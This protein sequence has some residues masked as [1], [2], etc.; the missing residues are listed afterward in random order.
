MTSE[1]N[2]SER[3]LVVDDSVAIVSLL[4][5]EI[6]P[7]G[8]YDV[9]AAYSGE[10]GLEAIDLVN[11]DLILC[12]LEMPGIS[13]LDMLRTLQEKRGDVPAI[14]M[15]AF[16]SEAVATQALR[17]GVKDYIVKPFTTD[18]ILA[19]IE[20]ALAERR[21]LVKLKELNRNLNEY[22]QALAVLQAISQATSQGLEPTTLLERII[23]AAVFAG[24]AQG[25]FVARLNRDANRLEVQA[26]ANLPNWEAKQI[27]L[28]LDPA[29]SAALG[30]TEATRTTSRAGYWY[31]IPLVRQGAS[32]GLMSIVSRFE[33]LPPSA[34][35]IF[36]T[37]AS[38]VAYTFENSQLRSELAV[39]LL[40][41]N[42]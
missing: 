2:R 21:L 38:C 22:H 19:S 18:E 9:T 20:R 35:P 25:G 24:K 42:S 16:G 7:L 4:A 5:N 14:M 39:A 10:E 17:M 31:H 32:I 13:G 8:G 6:L 3:I 12:D 36:S 29:L 23:L 40:Q 28:S 34:G 1:P 11:P 30:G 33:Q 27:D 26:V 37:L 15:T 41:G